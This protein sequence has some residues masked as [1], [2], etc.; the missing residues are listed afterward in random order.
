MGKVKLNITTRSDH[1]N[2][3]L[4]YQEKFQEREAWHK[5]VVK[6][7]CWKDGHL[8]NKITPKEWETYCERTVKTNVSHGKDKV[9]HSLKETKDIITNHGGFE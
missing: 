7:I 3:N 1:H 6:V 8:A 9:L 4:A 5:L 2:N